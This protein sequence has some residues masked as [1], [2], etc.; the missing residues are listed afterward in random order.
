MT[1]DLSWSSERFVGNPCIQ[2]DPGFC[3]QG[4]LRPHSRVTHPLDYCC[5]A[6]KLLDHA[7]SRRSGRTGKAGDRNRALLVLFRVSFFRPLFP[8]VGD[9]YRIRSND[10][11]AIQRLSP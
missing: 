4:L 10:R 7:A 5:T 11:A 6:A 2:S 3:S 8:F 1:N 9:P